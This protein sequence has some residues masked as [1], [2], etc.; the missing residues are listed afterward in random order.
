MNRPALNAAQA[1]VDQRLAHAAA[2]MDQAEAALSRGQ[3]ESIPALM[4]DLVRATRPLAQAAA[5]SEIQGLGERIRDIGMLAARLVALQAAVA[6]R[7]GALQRERLLLLGEQGMSPAA[8]VYAP[9]G[10][11]PTSSNRAA[12]SVA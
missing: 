12:G 3:P 2:L 5:V 6:R 11:A 9:D 1:A 10:R 7:Q 4:Q 8:G